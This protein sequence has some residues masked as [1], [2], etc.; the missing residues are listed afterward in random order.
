MNY[1]ELQELTPGTYQLKQ[2]LSYTTEHLSEDGAY[3]VKVTNQRQDLL[4]VQIQSRQRNSVEYDLYIRYNTK[5]IMDWYSKC[6][7]GS[8]V[9]GCYAHVASVM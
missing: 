7:N 5:T 3:L 2:T 9:V 1:D 6:P 8:R 4:G